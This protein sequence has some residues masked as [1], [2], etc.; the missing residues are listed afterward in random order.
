MLETR[1]ISAELKVS[2]KRL[3]SVLELKSCTKKQRTSIDEIKI[4][5]LTFSYETNGDSIVL[6]KINLHIK[7]KQHIAIMGETGS[8]KSTLCKLIAGLYDHFD[9]NINYFYNGTKVDAF[10]T[11]SYMYQN[12]YIFDDTIKNNICLS[13]PNANDEEINDVIE[14]CLLSQVVKVHGNE[15][16]GENGEKLSGGEKARLRLAQCLLKN[17]SSLYIFDELSS[18]LDDETFVTIMQNIKQRLYENIVLFVEH[19]KLVR[20]YVDRVVLIEG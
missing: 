12:S 20:D 17:D 9:G 19:N 16:L 14:C 10:P 2:E 18:S 5:N 11:I 3:A 8:G 7:P 1:K 15:K 13:N 4:N 6:D